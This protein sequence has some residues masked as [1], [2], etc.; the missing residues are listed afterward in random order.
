VQVL[1]A[2]PRD[3]YT[4]AQ[5]TALLEAGNLTVDF[6]ADL[7][8][9]NL[10]FV[11]DL[12]PDLVGGSV[13]RDCYGTVHG[14]CT[15]QLSRVLR[16]GVDLVRPYMVLS[17]GLTVARWNLGVYVLTT[18]QRTVGETPETY[19]VQ[20][21]DRLMLLNR[22]VGADYRVA[23]GV[24]Y[25][26][27]IVA[28]FAAAGLSGVLIDGSAADSTLPAARSWLLVG[29]S[30][31]PDQTATP[32][33]WLR[34]VNDLLNAINF[35]AVWCDQDGQFRCSGYQ[36][37][38]V[39]AP[40][41]V[42]DADSQLT[43]LGEDRTLTEDVWSTPNRWVFRQTN[44][45]SDAPTPTEGDGIYTRVN[46]T[47]GP[48]S[49]TGRGL[50]WTAVVDYE[51]ASH[52][53]LVSL[54]DRRVASDRRV[55]TALK[56]WT[57]PFPGAGHF[58]VFTYSDAAA[59]GTRKVQATGWRMPFD[60]GNVEWD[61]EAVTSASA[62]A[63]PPAPGV[64]PTVTGPVNTSLS[65]IRGGQL[66]VSVMGPGPFT[67]RWFN[68]ALGAFFFDGTITIAHPFT[69]GTF[70]P[71]IADRGYRV[72]V[73]NVFGTVTS[74]TAVVSIIPGPIITLHPTSQTVDVAQGQGFTFTTTAPGATGYT[75]EETGYFGPGVF[76]A[77]GVN[78][79]TYALTSGP[80]TYGVEANRKQFRCRVD[81]GVGVTYSNVATLTVINSGSGPS[82]TFPFTFPITFGGAANGFPLTFPVT[83][84]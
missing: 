46:D 64:L 45:S 73:T 69:A 29:D 68:N 54:G 35:R 71:E 28:A 31:N 58:D 74:A 20:G 52:A 25:R 5:I 22:Q 21:Y 39:R 44:R 78:T 38:K 67:Y 1:N 53:K 48:T 33:T 37:P 7:L 17:S 59:G 32:V 40:E 26:A 47:D 8:N 50:T 49:I 66:S 36:D 41:Y 3:A 83:F 76:Y 43:I 77:S 34:V 14:F 2:A 18:P 23:A 61:W 13:G 62:V 42:F 84:P 51:A 82:N 16:W 12:S 72:E 15:L 24:T 63:A 70:G 81:D 79:P 56:V 80:Y 30:T 11:D 9:L 6:G 75:W 65:V 57:G 27:A 19:D 10:G 60:G 55:T 4:T